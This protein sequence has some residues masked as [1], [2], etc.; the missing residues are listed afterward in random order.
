[1]TVKMFTYPNG[2]RIIYEKTSSGRQ[3]THI[4]AFCDVGSI[5]EPENLKGAAH[6]VE[7]MCFKGTVG[8]PDFRKIYSV[9]DNIGAYIN[10]STD[11]RYTKY[12]VICDTRHVESVLP[13]L[14]DMMLNSV[15][16]SADLRREEK[17]VIEE[18][19]ISNVD[20]SE[21]LF[22]GADT[23]L[24]NGTNYSRPVDS[25]EYHKPLF[26]RDEVIKFYKMYY[27]P[28]RM[29]LSITSQLSFDAI[30]KFISKTHFVNAC[31]S[32]E[33][34]Y[35]NINTSIITPSDGIQ[36]KLIKATGTFV[37]IGFRILTED[38]WP[39]ICLSAILS[40]TMNSR[41]WKLL[42]DDGGISYNVNSDCTTYEQNGDFLIYADANSS[43]I[44]TD[45]AKPGVLPLIIKLLNDLIQHGITQPE[46]DVAKG[47]L[48]GTLIRNS[49]RGEI[50]SNYNGEHAILFPGVP[51]VPYSDIYRE[52][53]A[54]IDKPAINDCIRKYFKKEFMSVCITCD[55]SI[56]ISAIKSI[57]EGIKSR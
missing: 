7:H 28:N 40:G 26:K 22:D 46:L 10:A 12:S 3:T 52:S 5:H 38:K 31:S 41:L 42:R 24:Y 15:F 19:T 13:T 44:I 4:Q 53:I 14:A 21:K 45:G 2:L 50:V 9:Y 36:Y 37:S 48:R 27:Q 56:K 35:P 30:R 17:I 25:L 18:N 51:I 34:V 6:F 1:M 49:E 32:T 20:P 54:N 16:N 43:K 55:K 11:K 23:M 39:F 8:K 29:V 33:Y 47:Y 57:C